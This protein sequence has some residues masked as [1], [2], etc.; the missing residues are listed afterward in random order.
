MNKEEIF[1]LVVRHTCEIIPEL[2][3]HHFQPS[4]RLADLGANSVDRAEIVAMTL[5]A[6]DLQ[7]P[8]TDLFGVKNIGELVD[9]LFEKS[10]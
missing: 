1:R 10:R 8:R 5:E 3:E 6:L 9:A 7:I 4:D 2:E